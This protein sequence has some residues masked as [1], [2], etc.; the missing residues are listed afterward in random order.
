VDDWWVGSAFNRMQRSSTSDGVF[1][2]WLWMGLFW[3]NG[4]NLKQGWVDGIM[5]ISR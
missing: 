3:E 2:G 4:G 1:V 5:N